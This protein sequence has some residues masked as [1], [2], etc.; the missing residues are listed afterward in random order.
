MLEHLDS[1]NH[2]HCPGFHKLSL[3]SKQCY[4]AALIHLLQQTRSGTIL[5]NLPRHVS[6][7]LS[8]SS[9]PA[10]LPQVP[11]HT[12]R[13]TLPRNSENTASDVFSSVAFSNRCF[14]VVIHNP[15]FSFLLHLAP[16]N[17][18]NYVYCPSPSQ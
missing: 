2:G 10:F 1:E 16:S 11:Q 6:L 7:L 9:P 12:L 18:P 17:L 3:D 15:D 13:K 5:L 8:L 4:L 14:P